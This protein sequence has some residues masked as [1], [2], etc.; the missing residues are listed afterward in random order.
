M[1]KKKTSHLISPISS[2]RNCPFISK[3]KLFTSHIS[4]NQSEKNMKESKSLTKK[5]KKCP[6]KAESLKLRA[7]SAAL[8]ISIPNPKRKN[9]HCSG[10]ADANREFGILFQAASVLVAYRCISRY[11]L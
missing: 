7:I 10:E 9:A 8:F 2:H 3:S 1:I 4:G 5:S 6:M 11:I